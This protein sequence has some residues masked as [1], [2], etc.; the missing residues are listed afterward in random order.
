MPNC[1]P[2][3]CV[4]FL[5]K[6]VKFNY[7]MW[8]CDDDLLLVDTVKKCI[9]F[10][11]KNSDYS[12]AGGYIQRVLIEQNQLFSCTKLQYD[13]LEDNNSFKRLEKLSNKYQV[14]QYAISRTE[15]MKLRYN[16]PD[17]DFD[18]RIGCELYP[19]FFLAAMGKIKFLNDLFCLRQ[20]HERR[21][22]FK[23]IS[24]VLNEKNFQNSLKICKKNIFNF[25]KKN[26]NK[27]IILKK[28]CLI[29]DNYF[30]RSLLYKKKNIYNNLMLAF[31]KKKL[32]VKYFRL[33][34][35]FQKYYFNF[36]IFKLKNY[37]KLEKFIVKN[38]VH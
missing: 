17:H 35:V 20:I 21:I 10:L 37:N 27:K 15:G 1:L 3:Q 36:S 25:L 32:G 26:E 2:H 14:I 7:S 13:N 33:K 4:N 24:S 8:I 31:I 19:T 16:I 34:Y 11:E 28:V 38:V 9:A 5:I 18:K 23:E 22:I 29:F 30:K 12:A 6:K